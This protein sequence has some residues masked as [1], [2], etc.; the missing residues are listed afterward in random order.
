MS[1]LISIKPFKSSRSRLF[2]IRNDFGS[3]RIVA[4]YQLDKAIEFKNYLVTHRAF[5]G[6]WP[7]LDA[8]GICPP[9][10]ITLQKQ[11]NVSQIDNMIHIEQLDDSVYSK[12]NVNIAVCH[13]FSFNLHHDN[14]TF[15]AIEFNTKKERIE[16]FKE[17][18]EYLM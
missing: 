11:H 5:R 18:L 12:L 7:I 15:R 4:F 17:R 6:Y 1:Y 13:H 8:S 2:T 3:P 9:I 14:V 10:Y 16:E